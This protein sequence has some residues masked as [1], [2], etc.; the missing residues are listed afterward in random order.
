[1]SKTSKT[2]NK[3]KAGK[4]VAGRVLGTTKDGVRILSANSSGAT[5]F[6]RKELRDAMATV[7]RAAKTAG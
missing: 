3:S 4:S 1:M 2:A 5:H 7:V 6:T